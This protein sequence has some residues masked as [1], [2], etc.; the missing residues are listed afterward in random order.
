MNDMIIYIAISVGIV[1]VIAIALL[2]LS[3]RG[4]KKKYKKMLEDLEYQKNELSSAPVGPELAKVESY[5][6]NEKLEVLYDDWKERLEDIKETTE[7]LVLPTEQEID[8]LLD[9]KV[10][11]I[12]NTDDIKVPERVVFIYFKSAQLGLLTVEVKH[13]SFAVF[14]VNYSAN[15]PII[16]FDT[17]DNIGFELQII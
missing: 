1:L 13:Y 2:I 10:L 8:K 17:I 6:K 14:S 12:I 11:P 5:A 3:R 4:K 7:T 16:V 15:A 9:T